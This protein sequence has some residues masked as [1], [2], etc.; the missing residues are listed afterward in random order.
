MLAVLYILY[1]VDILTTQSEASIRNS[2]C[3]WR[4]LLLPYHG[5]IND[6]YCYGIDI[7]TLEFCI[8]VNL[9]NIAKHKTSEHQGLINRSCVE[10]L[11]HLNEMVEE[12]TANSGSSPL[13][14]SKD[15]RNVRL[16]VCYVGHHERKA[17]D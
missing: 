2:H 9:A 12:K 15:E 7:C 17:N 6:E 10:S 4:I 14:M 11:S 1:G 16:V 8:F 5:V 3:H 13:R